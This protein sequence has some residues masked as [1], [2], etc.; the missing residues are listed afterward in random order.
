LPLLHLHLRLPLLSQVL[1]WYP[2][3]IL[4]PNFL[5]PSQAQ[6]FISLAADK[7]QPSE[8]GV[9]D[10]PFHPASGR[11]DGREVGV[12]LAAGVEQE[13]GNQ[14][15]C[16]PDSVGTPA[17]GSED[18]T[19]KRHQLACPSLLVPSSTFTHPAGP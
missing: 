11:T 10:V 17:I 8:L 9:A 5:S 12:S 16:T 4:F 13:A 14:Q 2:R 1:S 7:L 3:V 18:T 19:P 6:Y 15:K